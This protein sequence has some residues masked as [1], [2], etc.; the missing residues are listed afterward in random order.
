MIGRIAGRL[1]YRAIVAACRRGGFALY[2]PAG[3]RGLVAI[4]R[5]HDLGRKGMAPFVDVGARDRGEGILGDIGYAGRRWCQ[6]ID[7]DG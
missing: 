6:P 7:C 1:E 4:V 3:A 2:R 5:V